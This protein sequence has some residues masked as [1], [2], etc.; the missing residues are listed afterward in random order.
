MK[1]HIIYIVEDNPTESMLLKIALQQMNH[2]TVEY[3]SEGQALL[4]R[5][6][7]QPAD[8]VVSDLIMPSMSGQEVLKKV[9][10]LKKSTLMIVLS[11]QEHI[12]VV[13]QLQ[14]LG[15][16]NYIVKGDHCLHYLKRTLEVACFLLEKEFRF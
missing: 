2:L 16:F 10:K 11:S 8:I 9:R 12:E 4:N 13:A 5:F 15:I 3:F 6:K 14:A 7:E 1:K